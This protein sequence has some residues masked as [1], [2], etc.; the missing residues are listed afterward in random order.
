MSPKLRNSP[1]GNPGDR[2]RI[3]RP[4]PD[5]G[6]PRPHDPSK[7]AEAPDP[8]MG[9]M[10]AVLMLLTLGCFIAGIVGALQ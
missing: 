10:L 9:A 7:L 1:S 6:R 5:H 2:S 3:L 4:M 8:F